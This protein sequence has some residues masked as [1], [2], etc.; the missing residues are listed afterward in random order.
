MGWS[1]FFVV[2]LVALVV[3]GP[4]ELPVALRALGQIVSKVRRIVEE[5]RE[6]VND[7]VHEAENQSSFI[8]LKDNLVFEEKSHGFDEK[9]MAH[10]GKEDVIDSNASENK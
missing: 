8:G 9:S 7:F 10:R 5:F 3:I 4:R 6:G 2:G 1:E